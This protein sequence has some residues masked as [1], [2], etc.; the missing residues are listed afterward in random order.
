MIVMDY[1]RALPEDFAAIV[2]LQNR[3]LEWNLDQQMRY[4]G[5]LSTAFSIEQFK[6]MDEEVAIVVGVDAGKLCGYVCASTPAFN[7]SMPFPAAMLEYA[8]QTIYR[9]KALTSYDLCVTT[10][11]CIDRDYR[12]SG[13]YLGLCYKM[14]ELVWGRYD[15]AVGFIS[16]A[17]ARHLHAIQKMAWVKPGVFEKDGHSFVLIVLPLKPSLGGCPPSAA[18]NQ[19]APPSPRSQV[20]PAV[21]PAA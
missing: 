1:R 6:R 4:D 8:A 16:T 15:L 10:P 20:E 17:N 9:D 19:A 21:P 18:F 3:N 14:L 5:F 7:R 12:G 11:I 2:D 13:A